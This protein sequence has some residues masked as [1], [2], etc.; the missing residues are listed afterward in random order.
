M[1]KRS[2][3]ATYGAPPNASEELQ[4]YKR[5]WVAPGVQT[6]WDE[7]L[8]ELN[9]VSWRGA[10]EALPKLR[11]WETK[12]ADLRDSIVARGLVQLCTDQ[13]RTYVPLCRSTRVRSEEDAQRCVESLQSVRK[14]WGEGYA[15]E[16]ARL[17]E[18]MR[19]FDKWTHSDVLDFQLEVAAH[20]RCGIRKRG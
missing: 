5:L 20:A 10:K 3:R 16:L 18:K 7:L 2:P 15:G 1:A 11:R 13:P 14:R 12:I 6:K 9:L 8:S 19:T 17:Q 4:L